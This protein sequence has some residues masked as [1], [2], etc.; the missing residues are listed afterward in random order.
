MERERRSKGKRG[1]GPTTA[2]VQA[3]CRRFRRSHGAVI[4]NEA[5]RSEGSGLGMRDFLRTPGPSAAPQDDTRGRAGFTLIELLV[6]IAVIALLM[7]ILLPV[8]GRV[9]S[10]AKAVVCQSNLRQWGTI[11]ACYVADSEGGRLPND[12]ASGMW[13]LRGSALNK[14]DANEPDADQPVRTSGIACCPEAVRP[15]NEGWFSSSLSSGGSLSWQVE[16]T[17]GSTFAAWQIQSPGPP[18]CCSYG[19]NEWLFSFRFDMSFG[20]GARRLGPDTFCVKG[21]ANIPV[22]IDCA[23][24]GGRPNARDRPPRT[25][26]RTIGRMG[27]FCMNRHDGHVNGLFLDW[28]V[29]R[30][31]LKELW[32]LKWY[33][34][35]DTAG[36]W[37]TIGGVEPGDWPKWMRHFK[38]Y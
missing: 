33:M 19:F 6:V 23:T 12:A 17:L 29:R 15:R 2:V 13:L 1:P 25:A 4:L 24:P 10:Q 30:I 7:A 38:D 16:G 14:G 11:L 9:R 3:A 20:R 22:L 31:G 18:F 26:D 37:T 36:P 28:S 35:F 21:K 8:L 34:D 32:T 5:R 27:P